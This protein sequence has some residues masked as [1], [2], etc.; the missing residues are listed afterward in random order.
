MHDARS[1][2]CGHEVSRNNPERLV[3]LFHGLCPRDQLL[4]TQTDEIGAFHGRQHF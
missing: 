1:I 2:L 4:V 3:G